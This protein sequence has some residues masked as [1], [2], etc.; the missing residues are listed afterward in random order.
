MSSFLQSV[1]DV[2]AGAVQGAVVRLGSEDLPRSFAEPSSAAPTRQFLATEDGNGLAR[3]VYKFPNSDK[4][5][6]WKRS[7]HSISFEFTS[8]QQLLE[9]ISSGPSMRDSQVDLIAHGGEVTK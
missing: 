6:V 9:G 1:C 2:T 5:L 3:N 7:N 4:K 8:D